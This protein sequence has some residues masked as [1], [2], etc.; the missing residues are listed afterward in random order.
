MS[1]DFFSLIFLLPTLLHYQKLIVVDYILHAV[2]EIK[3]REYW[4]QVLLWRCNKS[5]VKSILTDKFPRQRCSYNAC[6]GASRPTKAF[7]VKQL[8]SCIYKI[9]KTTAAMEAPCYRHNWE[10]YVQTNF[11]FSSSFYN[12]LWTVLSLL[13][14]SIRCNLQF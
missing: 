3:H 8:G 12:P 5:N 11:S 1:K 9:T 7:K 4:D 10:R 6:G 14:L 2:M 13:F